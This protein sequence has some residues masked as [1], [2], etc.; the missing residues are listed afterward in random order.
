VK[1][2]ERTHCSDTEEEAPLR[3][4]L[5][6]RRAGL[7]LVAPA[8]FVL[9]AAPVEAAGPGQHFVEICS[10]EG[11]T[12]RALPDTGQLPS[13]NSGKASSHATCAHMMRPRNLLR[14]RRNRA[15]A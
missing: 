13:D 6:N 1:A 12:W 7:L 9:S 11:V 2:G 4:R 14:P 15:E 3:P 8:L 5:S 10:A